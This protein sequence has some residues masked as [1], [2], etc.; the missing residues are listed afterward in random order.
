MKTALWLWWGQKVSHSSFLFSSW[1]VPIIWVAPSE[2][3][4]ALAILLMLI[5]YLRV[6]NWMDCHSAAQIHM[7][8]FRLPHL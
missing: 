5:C 6:G 3:P 2:G 8:S 1:V 7:S 4:F